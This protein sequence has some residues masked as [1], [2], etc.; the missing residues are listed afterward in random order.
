MM[1]KRSEN[2]Y[3]K[4]LL[5]IGIYVGLF[6]FVLSFGPGMIRFFLPFIIAWFIA[7][8]AN[9][10][11]QFLDTRLNLVRKYSSILIILFIIAVIVFLIYM[12]ISFVMDQV[13]VLLTELP[14]LIESFIDTIN[15][16]VLNLN[17]TMSRFPEAIQEPVLELGESI[18]LSIFDF[19]SNARIPETTLDITRNVFDYILFL[20]VVFIASYFF[21]KDNKKITNGVKSI[22]PA[23]ILENYRIVSYHFKHAVGG[24]IT[25]Q[26]KLMAI[27]IVILYIGFK[28]IDVRF[29]FLIALITG[30]VD[31]LPILGTGFILWPW[32]LTEL[33]LG[34]YFNAAFLIIIYVLC[35]F[36][37]NILQPKV[38]GDAV[39][40]DALTTFILMF[41]GYRLSG[42]TG[43]ILSVPIGLIFY[44]LYKVGMFDNIIRGFKILIRDVNEYRKF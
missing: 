39:G 42:I 11:V 19:L 20:L 33:I 27:V 17:Q 22:T 38:V 34:N 1:D 31:L 36:I 26:L 29:A 15:K 30:F 32:A 6:L 41:I 35:Q 23:P 40:I 8:I 44:N 21:I 10:L 16:V 5:N 18:R 37:K 4:I 2:I 7:W 3:L 13:L 14:D 28:I 9:P 25:A 43:L 12:L 24:Y